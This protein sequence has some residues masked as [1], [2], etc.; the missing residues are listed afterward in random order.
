MML[1]DMIFEDKYHMS[2]KSGFCLLDSLLMLQIITV[3][4]NMFMSLGFESLTYLLYITILYVIL[5]S[6]FPIMYA[7][8]WYNYK[9]KKGKYERT[10]WERGG[11]IAPFI[12]SIVLSLLFYLSRMSL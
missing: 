5:C 9:I 12:L 3:Y 10:K 2:F 6:V 1:N 11:F 4:F 8:D 7:L